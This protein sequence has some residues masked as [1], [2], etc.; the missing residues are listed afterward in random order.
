M[1]NHGGKHEHGT[2]G[3]DVLD[4]AQ[5]ES[6]LKRPQRATA[7]AKRATLKNNRINDACNGRSREIMTP[8][9]RANAAATSGMR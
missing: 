9:F 6:G 7:T 3:G 4:G 5:Q 8:S 1:G 2:E